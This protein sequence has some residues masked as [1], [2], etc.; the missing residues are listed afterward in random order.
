MVYHLLFTAKLMYNP[1]SS[2]F[3]S[4]CRY[5]QCLNTYIQRWIDL[6]PRSRIVLSVTHRSPIGQCLSQ[7]L[8]HFHKNTRSCV[9]NEWCCRRA[10]DIYNVNF[11]KKRCIPAE[12][13][14]LYTGQ[15]MTGPDNSIDWS[16]RHESE[17]WGFESPSGRDNFC[18][19]T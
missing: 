11:I 6:F 10:V 9:E 3:D 4:I 17:G 19:K 1:I 13:V 5:L 15:Q 18:L 16:I 2:I 7:K 12:P 8:W 14:F